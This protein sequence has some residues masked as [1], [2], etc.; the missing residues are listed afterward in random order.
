[1]AGKKNARSVPGV[2]GADGSARMASQEPVAAIPVSK[3]SQGKRKL[4]EECI[5][6]MAFRRLVQ[7]I[8]DKVRPGMRYQKEAADALQEAAERELVGNFAKC[9]RLAELCRKDTVREEHW[10]FVQ[11]A[12]GDNT[13][14]G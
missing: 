10:Q 13:L 4:P 12:T 8:S 9:S 5:P 14:L 3:K 1:L 2:P 11:E 7:E 6:R